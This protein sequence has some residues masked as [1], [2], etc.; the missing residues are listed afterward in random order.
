MSRLRDF[1]GDEQF[2]GTLATCEDDVVVRNDVEL[3]HSRR[4]RW[5]RAGILLV[6]VVSLIYVVADSFGSRHV[7]AGLLNFLSWVQDHPYQGVLAVICVYIVA[8]ILFIPGSVLT[9]GAGFAFGKACSSTALGVLLASIVSV[10]FI[11]LFDIYLKF[12]EA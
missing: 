3:N 12:T 10:T 2:C 7:E 11:H 9:L 1:E 8:T 6:L 4:K 5:I